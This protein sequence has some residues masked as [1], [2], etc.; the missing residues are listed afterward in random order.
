M[1]A[2]DL[3]QAYLG[4]FEDDLPE[5]TESEHRMWAIAKITGHTPKQRLMTWMEWNGIFGY[6]ERA[7]TIATT[8][9]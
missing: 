7:Y 4:T 8:G 2:N 9:M 1:F 3:I 5:G 6:A